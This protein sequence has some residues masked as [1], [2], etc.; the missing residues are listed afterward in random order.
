[1]VTVDGREIPIP[2]PLKDPLLRPF[3]R[4]YRLAIKEPEHLDPKSFVTE[5]QKSG[6]RK[7]MDIVSNRPVEYLGGLAVQT[8]QAE[9][10]PHATVLVDA[11]YT[12]VA[13]MRGPRMIGNYWQCPCFSAEDCYAGIFRGAGRLRRLLAASGTPVLAL[14]D[15]PRRN[16]ER[17]RVHRDG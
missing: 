10:N 2:D 12:H 17:E 11:M 5:F 9:T 3:V 6:P 7:W 1:S 16:L 14:V 8:A 13:L 4:A 15:I